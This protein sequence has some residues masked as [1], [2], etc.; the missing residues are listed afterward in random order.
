[1]LTELEIR[2]SK[3]AEKVRKLSDGRGLQLWIW[4]NGSKLWRLAYRHGGKQKVLALGSYPEV[5]LK[6]ARERRDESRKVLAAG[7]DPTEKKKLDRLT[8]AAAAGNTFD[9]LADEW[10]A[11]VSR[12]GRAEATLGKVTWLLSLARPALGKRPIAEISALEMLDTLRT[13]ER[14]GRLESARRLRSTVSCVFRFAIATGRAENDPTVPLRGALAAPVAK[15]RAAVTDPG[16]F[17]GLLRAIDGFDGQSTT[18]IALQLLAL[19]A[20]RPGELRQAGWNEFDLDKAKWIIPEG[21]TKM[22]R[23]HEV[24]LPRQAVELLRSLWEITGG[25]RYLFP[26]IRSSVR[27]MS[28]NTLNAALRRL[29]YDKDEACSHGFR[30][31][32]STIANESG[33]WSADAIERALAHVDGND[34][35]RAYHRGAHWSE[36]VELAQWWA[37]RCDELRRS[38][39]VIPLRASQP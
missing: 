22:R 9:V 20:V 29:G 1:M 18:K 32:F 13:V 4:P 10:L 30:S 7:T 25:S 16:K 2:G 5:S 14:R 11:K 19:T 28:E 35:R 3:P 26:S 17:G 8:K 34:I 15:H 27:C 39:Q 21:R 37:D 12:E 38:T 33:K 23:A 36:R 6:E 31:S 24:P